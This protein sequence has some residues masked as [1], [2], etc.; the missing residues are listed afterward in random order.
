MKKYLLILALFM[1]CVTVPD[2][3]YKRYCSEKIRIESLTIGG[4]FTKK[5][6]PNFIYENDTQHISVSTLPIE[7]KK[8]YAQYLIRI[9]Y[10]D[11]SCHI[12]EICITTTKD[13]IVSI[14][15]R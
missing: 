7:L 10:T 9:V 12:Q 4:R 2:E 6:L 8:N 5:D 11:D 3:A 1:G 13:T 15:P 14:I